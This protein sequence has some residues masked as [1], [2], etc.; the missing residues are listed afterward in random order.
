MKIIFQIENEQEVKIIDKDNGKMCGRIFSPGGTTR[1]VPNAIQICGFDFAY[2]L[3]GCGVI[4][5]D[6]GLHKKDIQLLFQP[7]KDDYFKIPYKTFECWRCF[8]SKEN[9]TC[10]EFKVF[11]DIKEVEEFIEERRK[12]KIKKEVIKELK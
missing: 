4:T 5:G 12:T 6:D 10:K 2:E 3:F 9:C 1:N 11:H 7:R 8:N